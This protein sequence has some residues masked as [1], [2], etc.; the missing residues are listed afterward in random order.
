MGD[1]QPGYRNV[2]DSLFLALALGLIIEAWWEKAYVIIV[3]EMLLADS[4][5]K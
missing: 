2:D 3:T 5:G 1:Y 4:I